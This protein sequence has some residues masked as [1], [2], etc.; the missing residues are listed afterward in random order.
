MP[1][2]YWDF[3]LYWDFFLKQLNKLG[4]EKISSIQSGL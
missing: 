2:W 3:Y 1:F 4:T